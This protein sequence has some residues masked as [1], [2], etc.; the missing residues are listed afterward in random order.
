MGGTTEILQG[1][2]GLPSGSKLPCTPIPSREQNPP[3]R[4]PHFPSACRVCSPAAGA[5][6]GRDK[7]GT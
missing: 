2:G 5:Q 6:Q 4:H 3:P 1:T 7:L